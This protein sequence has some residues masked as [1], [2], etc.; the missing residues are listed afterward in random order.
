MRQVLICLLLVA[1]VGCVKK[2]IPTTGTVYGIVKDNQTAQPLAG[3]SIMLMPTGITTVTGTDGSFHFEDLLPG[4][5]SVEVS[6]YGY[7]NE[8]KSIIVQAGEDPLPVDILLAKNG[9]IH[10]IVKDN[11]SKQALAGC[12]VMLMPGGTT[13]VTSSDGSFQFP[14]LT[15]G[16]YSIEV[17]CHGYQNNK[18]NVT[19]KAGENSLSMDILLIKELPTSGAIH[20]VVKDSKNSQPLAGCSVMLMPGGTTI[21][22]GSDGSFQFNNITPGDYSVEVSYDGYYNEKKSVVVKASESSIPL[23]IVLTKYDANNRLAELG[24]VRIEEVTF[25]SARVECEII[26]QGSSSVTERGFLYSETPNV[27]IATATKQIVKTTEDIFSAR[28]SN[29]AERTDYYVAAYAING[30]G[31]AY[32]EVMKFTTGDAST[33]T[34]PANVIYVSV[35]GND[36]NDGSSWSKAKRTIKAAIDM[37][38]AG[39][40]IWV[41]AGSFSETVT[42]KNGIPIY[43]GFSGNEASTD[44]RT[45]RTGI[46]YLTCDSYSETTIVNGFELKGSSTYPVE[47]KSHILLENCRIADTRYCKALTTKGESIAMKDCVIEGCQYDYQ[48]IHIEGNTTMTNC[49]IRG[50][51]G[52]ILVDESSLTMYNCVV[53]NNQEGIRANSPCA[54]Y[55]CTIANNEKYGFVA[56]RASSIY[57]CLIWNNSLEEHYYGSSGGD[58][59]QYSSLV[60]ESS[61]N[62]SVKFKRPS[63][64]AGHEAS[65]W[66]TA[67]WSITAGSECINAG[68]TLYFPTADIPTDIAGNPR[69]S[70]SSI[71]IGAYEW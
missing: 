43:G 64:K 42:P 34:A 39:K 6:C 46:N 56:Q 25:N 10:G 52:G 5:Y 28:L 37:A 58:I 15:P 19:V 3:C 24:A 67:D 45:Q 29:L 70:G 9:I 49:I 14:N 11:G 36:S 69:V 50:N 53:T 61:N 40:Q 54:L 59:S 4:T 22:T 27:T 18:K 8:K 57:N 1:F 55:N 63:S 7:N 60:I 33:V 21:V 47:L 13:V 17:T 38:T 44:G 48:L 23:D 26:E 62:Q 32:S 16:D 41:S 65:D 35:S 2:D 31:T 71:D 30:R 51:K 20:G 12:A 66:Q 68:T